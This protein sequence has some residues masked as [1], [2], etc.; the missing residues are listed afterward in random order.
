MGSGTPLPHC[1]EE[2]LFFIL[3]SLLVNEGLV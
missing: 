2:D 3:D 1:E